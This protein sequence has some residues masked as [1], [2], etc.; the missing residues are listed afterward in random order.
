MG[1]VGLPRSAPHSE[2]EVYD[3]GV[4]DRRFGIVSVLDDVD[5]F[6]VFEEILSPEIPPRAERDP[7]ILEQAVQRRLVGVRKIESFGEVDRSCAEFAVAPLAEIH[8]KDTG[9]EV[10]RSGIQAEFAPGEGRV[11]GTQ[12]SDP[13][14]EDG[15]DGLPGEIK[16]GDFL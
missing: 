3:V 2:I 12:P 9:V 5:E 8:D 10:R 6:R 1:A 4:I 13:R 14:V 7:I 16:F 11:A 15:A